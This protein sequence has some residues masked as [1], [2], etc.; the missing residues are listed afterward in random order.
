MEK[1]IGVRGNK[2][3]T[4]D[5][6]RF[7]T[8]WSN[9]ACDLFLFMVVAL[10]IQEKKYKWYQITIKW[11]IIHTYAFKRYFIIHILEWAEPKKKSK[12]YYM[13][14]FQCVSWARLFAFY[15]IDPEYSYIMIP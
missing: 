11:N 13:L 5:W 7:I 12:I 6:T 3:K 8:V 10:S 14:S 1:L 2:R 15:A 4:G 9:G